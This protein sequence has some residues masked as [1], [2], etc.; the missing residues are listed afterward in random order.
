MM[1]HHFWFHVIPVS[2][3]MMQICKE[4]KLYFI[5][6]ELELIFWWFFF[7]YMSPDILLNSKWLNKTVHFRFQSYFLN[8]SLILMQ[9]LIF[10]SQR[11]TQLWARVRVQIFGIYFWFIGIYFIMEILFNWNKYF[12]KKSP[13]KHKITHYRGLWATILYTY[14]IIY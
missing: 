13:E 11:L 12:S 7:H 2:R 14:N 6:G 8:K 3:T 1:E 9:T 5:A 10:K 4:E